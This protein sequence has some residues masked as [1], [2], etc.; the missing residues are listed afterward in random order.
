VQAAYLAL[1]ILTAVMVTFSGILK[2]RHDPK[3]VKVIHEIVGVPMEYLPL[4]ATGEFAG[5]V[6]MVAGIWWPP[7]G[8]AAGAGLAIYFVGAVVSHLRVGDIAG[9]GPAMF[10]LALSSAALVTR[11]MTM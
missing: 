8:L 10:V 4:L 6:G 3:V 2:I 7:L 5:A 11:W 9:I 1:T